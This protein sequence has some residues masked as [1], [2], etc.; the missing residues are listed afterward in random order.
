MHTY[1]FIPLPWLFFHISI[2]SISDIFVNLESLPRH[3]FLLDMFVAV[4][5]TKYKD[6]ESYWM[7]PVRCVY[8]AVEYW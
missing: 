7:L 3:S 8:A 1:T 4:S 5:S 2:I 6:V